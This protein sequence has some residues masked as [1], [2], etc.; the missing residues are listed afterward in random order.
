MPYTGG[1]W[2][3]GIIEGVAAML[4]LAII[5]GIIESTMAR[6]RLLRVPQLLVAAGALSTIALLLIMR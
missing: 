1:R 2:Y 4:M 5:I 3:V 6:L